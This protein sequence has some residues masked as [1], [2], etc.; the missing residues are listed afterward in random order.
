MKLQFEIPEPRF[1]EGDT[2][3]YAKVE[4]VEGIITEGFLVIGRIRKVLYQGS[5]TY[6]K[7]KGLQVAILGGEYWLG[8]LEGHKILG[9]PLNK[10]NLL[11]CSIFS[12]DKYG[13]IFEK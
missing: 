4:S 10:E 9:G 1:S 6:S 11:G 13:E 8:I 12:L 7:E 5:W 3:K 2:V